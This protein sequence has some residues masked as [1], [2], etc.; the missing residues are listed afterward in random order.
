MLGASV[1]SAQC[2]KTGPMETALGGF[3]KLH[4]AAAVDDV[5]KEIWIIHMQG[6]FKNGSTGD[7]A[8]VIAQCSQ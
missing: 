8:R 1:T 2:M 5:L 6:G 3:W 7:T 4:L